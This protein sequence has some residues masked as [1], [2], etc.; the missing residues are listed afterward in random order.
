MRTLFPT[1]LRQLQ[2]LK[3]GWVVGL[4]ATTI[5]AGAF[6]ETA[7]AQGSAAL[8]SKSAEADILFAKAGLPDGVRVIV[9]LKS[10]TKSSQSL[11][12]ASTRG[13]TVVDRSGPLQDGQVA[14]VEQLRIIARH[15]GANN[16]KRQRWAAVFG[17][18]RN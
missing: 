14:T 13:S 12:S 15:I 4:V 2:I 9:T 3:V 18:K 8:R 16:T 17:M 10:A 11:P 6:P 1:L 7:L 5:L